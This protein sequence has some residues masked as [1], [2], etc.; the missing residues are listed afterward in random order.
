M[1]VAVDPSV[2][3]PTT[4]YTYVI[5]Q[6]MDVYKYF[7]LHFINYQHVSI[8]FAIII[9][10]ALQKYKEYNN[11]PY[12]TSGTTQCYNKCLKQ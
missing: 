5:N 8:A 6:Q 2:E 12:E 10:I 4:N 7:S 9:G 1:K 11:L 3:Q